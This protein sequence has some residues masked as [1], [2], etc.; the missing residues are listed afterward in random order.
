[1]LLL[2]YPRCLGFVFNPLAVYCAFDCQEQLVGV[3]YEVRNTFGDR[4][5]Y[6]APVA[7]GSLTEAG[8]R[9]RARKAFY[10]SPF[11]DLNGAYDFRLQVDE[12]GVRL[13]ILHSDPD[14][15]LL[16]TGFTGLRRP[17]TSS[18]LLAA[19]GPVPLMTLKVV[20]GIHWQALR[21]WWKGL[22]LFPR[23]ASASAPSK[24]APPV[25]A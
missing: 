8:L 1:V 20:A 11:I 24:S 16:S 12:T 6:V 19:L 25:Q 4:H 17:L 10:V 7:P 2:A 9:Q 21:L 22:K 15:P 5:T 13:R 23:P 14:G 18:S 3:L